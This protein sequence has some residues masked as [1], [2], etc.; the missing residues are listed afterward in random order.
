MQN[1]LRLSVVF[2]VPLLVAL[3]NLAHPIVRAPV[4]D[5]IF[6]N[7]EWWITLHLLNL[8]GFPLLGLAAYLLI[9]DCKNA[10]AMVAKIGIAVFVPVYAAFDALAGVGTGTLVREVS[11]LSPDQ[12]TSFRPTVDAFWNSPPLATTAAVGSIAWAI[13][14]LSTAVAVTVAVWV[15]LDRKSHEFWRSSVSLTGER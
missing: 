6:L 8:A 11:C 14:M 7:L 4:Y 3:L 13:A 12:S 10:A 15:E 2:A 5:G 1:R 9:K